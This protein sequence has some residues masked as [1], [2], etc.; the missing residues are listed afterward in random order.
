MDHIYHTFLSPHRHSSEALL[1][2]S[3]DVY[4]SSQD[5]F[6]LW[7]TALSSFGDWTLSGTSGHGSLS[8]YSVR[9]NRREDDQ[10]S[11]EQSTK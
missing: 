7:Y 10:S 8:I 4:C 11:V 9:W 3:P 2:I 6:T 1:W 5:H